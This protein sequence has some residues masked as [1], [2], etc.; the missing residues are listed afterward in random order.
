MKIY[1][2]I[3]TGLAAVAMTGCKSL[4][5]KYERP[6]VNTA[7]LVRDA[8]SNTDTLAVTDT[9]SFA[10]IPWRSVFTDPQ[11]Q[12]L[13]STCLTN[14]PDLLNAA[15][16]V[17]MAEAQLKAAKLAFLPGI[18]FHAAGNH[19]LVGLQQSHEDL[20]AANQRQL[21]CQPLRQPHCRQ[22]CRTGLDAPD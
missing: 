13:I 19:H 18:S 21:G 11:L 10:N 1:Q 4:Y 15:L 12:S 6:Q 20:S 5:G 3:L 9:T 16:N 7:G 14:N 2:F 17:D 22:A 8:V